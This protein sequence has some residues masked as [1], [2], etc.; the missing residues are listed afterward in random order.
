MDLSGKWHDISPADIKHL[1]DT[2]IAKKQEE[3]SEKNILKNIFSC[4]D[5]TSL[6]GSDNEEK[7]ARFCQKA[8]SFPEKGLPF[9]AAVCVYPAFVRSAKRY[10]A[11]TG[12][13]VA[14]VTGYFPSGQAPLFLK[15]EEVKYTLDEGADEVDFVISRGK[16]LEGDLNYVYDEIASVKEL[17]KKRCLKVILETGELI[18]SDNIRRASE[19]AISAGA[20]FIKTSTGKSLPSATEEAAF[21]M[22]HVINE[23]YL[24]TGHKIGFKP[25][26]GITESLQAMRYYLLVLHILG[27]GW[28]TKDYFRIGAS[29]LADHLS[30]EISS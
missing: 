24:K 26:G 19:I 13:G 8:T 3:I 4:I 12:I 28:L 18:T 15:M 14:A 2:L 27:A 16:F 6:D 9:P 7:I 21:V 29:R 30:E 1:I 25:S 5:L 17:V 11:G 10:L 22:S 20:D 23:H